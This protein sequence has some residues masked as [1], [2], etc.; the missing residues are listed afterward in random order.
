[1]GEGAFCDVTIGRVGV[2]SGVEVAECRGRKIL[3]LERQ[4]SY[5]ETDSSPS[6]KRL[7]EGERVTT[8]LLF[9]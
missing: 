7:G 4:L 1:M 2:K 9:R 8:F 5:H 6:R 3:S